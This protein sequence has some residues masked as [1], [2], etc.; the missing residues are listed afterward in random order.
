VERYRFDPEMFGKS[1]A[2]K[3]L[4]R[5]FPTRKIILASQGVY[6]HVAI[7][8]L[9][10]AIAVFLLFLTLSWGVFV[11]Y[12]YVAHEGIL[13]SREQE[14]SELRIAHRVL[15]AQA[16][17]Q[18]MHIA[19][20]EQNLNDKIAHLAA[21]SGQNE[22]MG[23]EVAALRS[24]LGTVEGEKAKLA[25]AREAVNKQLAGLQDRLVSSS[26]AKNAG[27]YPQHG[28]A[29]ALAVGEIPRRPDEKMHVGVS[30]SPS[31]GP[32]AEGLLNI[33]SGM[34]DV[35]SQRDQA[36][37]EQE[38]L[39]DRLKQLDVA[40]ADLQASQVQLLQR[41]STLTVGSTGDVEKAF[42]LV[43]LDAGSLLERNRRNGVGGPFVPAAAD[44]GSPELRATLASL[45]MK[46][47]RLDNMSAMARSLPLAA[48]LDNY[49]LNSAYGTRND[50]INE[51]TGV[52]EG[53]DLGS[54]Y[55]NPSVHSTAPG[56]VVFAGW[57][58]RYGRMVEIDHGMGIHTRYAHLSKIS[59]RVGQKLDIGASVGNMGSSGRSTG[60]HLHYEVLVDGK[61]RDPMK[62]LK[63]GKYVLKKQQA[64]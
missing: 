24:R 6:R 64:G 32:V 13:A 20:L 30:V 43:G 44:F 54:P 12:R 34:R 35:I 60:Q 31:G 11:S 57:R 37:T 45:N 40:F 3:W 41:V 49:T 29:V 33:E 7:S 42:A 4:A 63:A 38:S 61:P 5:T 9:I 50:P 8:S 46:L 17:E 22:T 36:M 59:V 14:L 39:K 19:Q 27:T 62:F 1:D 2:A 52:H 28:G 53:I 56:R 21:L 16:S 51:L 18:K 47:D 10:Q 55:R 58:G 25:E 15:A 48:P 26:K 23:R